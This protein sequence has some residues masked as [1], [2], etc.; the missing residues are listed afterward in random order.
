MAGIL[1]PFTHEWPES[2]HKNLFA[3]GADSPTI[4]GTL[5]SG[6]NLKKGAILEKSS[7]KYTVVSTPANACAVLAQD[8]N[9]SGDDADCFVYLGGHFHYED[10]EW[11][12]MS[13]ADKKIA[14]EALANAGITVDTDITKVEATA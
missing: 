6:N 1:G 5:A 2:Q 9:A 4:P 11:P 14:L 13:A 8:C 12:T 3:G 7:S 10:L